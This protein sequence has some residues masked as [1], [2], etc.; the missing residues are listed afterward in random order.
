V[1]A[2]LLLIIPFALFLLANPVIAHDIFV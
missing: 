2:L 1:M